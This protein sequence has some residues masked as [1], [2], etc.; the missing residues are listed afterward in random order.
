[1]KKLLLIFLLAAAAVGLRAQDPGRA[2]NLFLQGDYATALRH[3]RLLHRDYPGTVLYTYRLGR[4]EQELGMYELAVQHLIEAGDR[5]SMRPF[6]LARAAYRT[7]R[8]DLAKE[9]FEEFL[10]SNEPTE[11]HYAA[12]EDEL[13]KAEQGARFFN[14]IENIVLVDTVSFPIDSLSAHLPVLSSDMGKI[15]VENGRFVSTNER[16][17]RRFFS[18]TDSKSGRTLI[19]KQERLLDRWTEIDTLPNTVN[20]WAQQQYPFLMPD[21]VTLYFSA[22]SEQG[23]GG[24]DIYVTKYNPSTNTYLTPEPLGM[25]FNSFD[26]DLLFLYDEALGQGCF[27]TDRAS[28]DGLFTLYSFRREEPYFLREREDDYL[29]SY[30][31]LSDVPWADAASPALPGYETLVSPVLAELAKPAPEWEL[32]VNDSIVYTALSDFRNA[33]ARLKMEEYLDL[34]RQIA[35]EEADLQARRLLYAQAESTDEKATLAPLILSL[36][37][38]VHRLKRELQ[39]LHYETLRLE[40]H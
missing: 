28:A 40:L 20:Q 6:W 27:L 35:E 15:A 36:E 1:M 13:R 31:Q 32:I 2:D 19:G 8:F 29:R 16:G 24:W 22:R 30:V 4:C 25:P 37:Q 23:L 21:G 10:D 34:S 38:D 11:S 12:A 3:Y 7:Y 18:F 17:D 26:D 9:M 14:R 39:E 5:Y 33:D